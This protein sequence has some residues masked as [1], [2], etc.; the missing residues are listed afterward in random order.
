MKNA[1]GAVFIRDSARFF[2]GALRL[3]ST[4]YQQDRTIL[5]FK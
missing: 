5:G 3:T 4:S 2:L 1:R